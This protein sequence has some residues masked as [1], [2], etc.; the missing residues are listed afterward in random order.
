[1]CGQ[2][3]ITGQF[4]SDDITGRDITRAGSSSNFRV[5]DKTAERR[6]EIPS[7]NRH[8]PPRKDGVPFD[9][10]VTQEAGNEQSTLPK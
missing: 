1:M 10:R 7:V 9:Q 6:R 4:S 2:Q 8:P 3:R 5:G